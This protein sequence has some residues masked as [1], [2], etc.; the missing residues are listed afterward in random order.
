[1]YRVAF[2]EERAA[3]QPVRLAILGAG[4]VAQTKYLPALA[5]LRTRSQPIEVVALKTRTRQNR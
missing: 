4:G 3:R 5:Q 2:A 1:V